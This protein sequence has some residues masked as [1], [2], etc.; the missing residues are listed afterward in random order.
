MS[1][2]ENQPQT[3]AIIEMRIMLGRTKP[4]LKKSFQGASRF[5]QTVYGQAVDQPEIRL[6][7]PDTGNC[8]WIGPKSLELAAKVA[9][10]EGSKTNLSIG[11]ATRRDA[12]SRRK[13]NLKSFPGAWVNIDFKDFE[14]DPKNALETLSSFLLKPSILVS[15]GGGFPAYW[16][17]KKPHQI[18][19]KNQPHFEVLNRLGTHVVGGDRPAVGFPPILRISGTTNFPN[20]NK[21][22]LGPMTDSVQLLRLSTKRYRLSDLEAVVGV[23]RVSTLPAEFSSRFRQMLQLDPNLHATWN[24]TRADL[25]D[26]SRL[27]YDIAMADFLVR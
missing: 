26:K 4:K 23:K 22:A 5:L 1:G 13:N 21:R 18:P 27:G 16:L 24:S 10:R 2:G 17:L 11:G 3:A 8:R 6:I 12:S 20:A 9:V 14:N 7:D 19:C 15:S 25:T